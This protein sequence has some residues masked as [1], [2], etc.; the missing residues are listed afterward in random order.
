MAR[1]QLF[2]WELAAPLHGRA[3]A[4]VLA[5]GSEV[6]EDHGHGARAAAHRPCWEGPSSPGEGQVQRRQGCTRGARRRGLVGTGTGVA[7][8]QE[9][10][11]GLQQQ[12]GPGIWR[13]PSTAGQMLLHPVPCW[14]TSSHAASES[15]QLGRAFPFTR[16][17]SYG[18]HVSPTAG[19]GAGGCSQLQGDGAAPYGVN[20]Q[21]SLPGDPQIGA[22]GREAA[23]STRMQHSPSM[24]QPAPFQPLHPCACTFTLARI[25]S[26][27]RMGNDES[28]LPQPHLARPKESSAAFEVAFK[29]SQNEDEH[30]FDLQLLLQHYKTSCELKPETYNSRQQA[31][32][33][34]KGS[35]ARAGTKLPCSTSPWEGGGLG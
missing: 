29:G 25:L 12:L 3:A 18:G 2:T 23:V 21:Q 11:R 20:K 30:G 33:W 7:P 14:G 34:D 27:Q 4:P 8:E 13:E 1:T 9:Q 28:S 16:R 31:V 22:G 10:H 24:L 5:S 6:E 15:K 26:W 32:P 19:V 17:G 35:P